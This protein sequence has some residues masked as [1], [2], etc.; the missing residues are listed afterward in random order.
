ML[1]VCGDMR[2]TLHYPNPWSFEK[3]AVGC[4]VGVRDRWWVVFSAS[5]GGVEE[6]ASVRA[7][8]GRGG[9]DDLGRA[10]TED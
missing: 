3:E 5:W 7:K 9:G 10:E 2:S 1:F 6:R 8:R 4:G